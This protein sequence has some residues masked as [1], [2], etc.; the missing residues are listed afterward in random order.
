[1]VTDEPQ[2][3]TR[4]RAAATRRSTVYHRDELD[5][6]IQRQF[7]EMRGLHGPSSTTRPAPPKSAAAA[8]AARW[9]TPAKTVVIN[10]L[11]CE[12]C[13]DCSV[14]SN[15][16]SVEPVETE[17]GRK[18][19]INQ[20]T[21]NKDYSCVKG[22]CPASSPSKAGSCKK[23][24]KEKK[25]D[26][27]SLPAHPRAGSCPRPMP[28]WGIVVAGVGGTGVITIGSLLGMA[29]HLEGKGVITQDAAGLAQRGG[30]TWSHIQIANTPE[31]HP[32]HHK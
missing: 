22:F 9:P 4:A 31:R 13:G 8:S 17:F 32:H 21:C 30:A 7:R 6:R 20:S 3:S 29:A 5:D 15:C 24:K 16:L 10:E 11:V 26:L 12:G 23:P 18:R 27:S 1:M 25:G 28:A 19:R 14:Q 2:T